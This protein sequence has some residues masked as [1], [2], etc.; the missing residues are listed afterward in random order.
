VRVLKRMLDK[1]VRGNNQS[2][3]T[4]AQATGFCLETISSRN[5]V[6]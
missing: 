1:E 4:S 5:M 2:L 3:N 6:I